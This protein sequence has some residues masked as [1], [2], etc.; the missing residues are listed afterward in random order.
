MGQV[1]HVPGFGGGIVLE[2]SADAQRTDELA[3]GD[4]Y[5][6]GP[7]GQLVATSDLSNYV[8]VRSASG[9]AGTALSPVRAIGVLPA[10]QA[11]RL[12]CVGDAGGNTYISFA[13][14]VGNNIGGA[15]KGVTHA[16]GYN[17]T[18][19]SFPYVDP[20]GT[21]LRLVLVCIGARPAYRPLAGLGVFAVT[22]NP[23]G[24]SYGSLGLEQYDSLGT[25]P[26]GEFTGGTK[27]KQLYPRGVIAYNNHA[28]F[29]GYDTHDTTDGD[30]QNR[31]MFSNTGK[32]LKIGRDADE[33]GIASGEITASDRDFEDSDAVSIGGGGEVIRA[34]LVWASRLWFGTSDGIHYVEGYGRESFKT[35]GAIAI[36]GSRN[37]IGP[38]A[39]IEGPD[40]LLHAVGDEGHW[41]FDGSETDPVGTK[42]RDFDAKS[43]GYWD[44]IWTDSSRTLAQFPGQSNQDLVWMLSD[45]ELG[46][47]LI[48]I[49]YCDA[50]AGYGYGTD[51]VVIKYHVKTG[52]YTRQVFTGKILLTAAMFRREHTAIAQHFVGGSSLGTNVSRYRYKA[53][54]AASPAMPSALPDVTFG[55]YAPFGPDGVGVFRKRYLTIAWKGAALPIVFSLTPTVDGQAMAAVKLS[56]QAT[57]PSTPSNGDYWLDTSGTDTNIG[58]GTAGAIVPANASDFIFRE[59]VASWN[60]WV[61]VAGG[62]QQG[63]RVSLP[64]AFAAARGTRFKVRCQ[65]TAAAARFQLEGFGEKPALVREGQ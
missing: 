52:G 7:R 51:T 24:P 13:D 21:Q 16:A 15:A 59:W 29:W 50:S 45:P 46:Q 35:N 2:G 44:L 10:P 53:T 62:G 23:A 54:A 8:D 65:C 9:G 38:H 1:L 25:G 11:P 39:M 55:E 28:F 18:M 42:L 49:P 3:A 57:A 6:I 61:P 64:I 48:G 4:G 32:P 47:V 37:V 60:K 58:N 36:A 31:A 34:A 33:D 14:L 20:T 12:V 27:S 63:T 40:R 22:Y 26:G 56:L 30:G 17:I 5:D 41:I 19:A 43:I